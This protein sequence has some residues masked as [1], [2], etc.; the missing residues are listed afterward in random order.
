METAN[1]IGI[2]NIPS[3][4]ERSSVA[5][6]LLVA[7]LFPAGLAGLGALAGVG[8]LASAAPTSGY[9]THQ[10]SLDTFARHESIPLKDHILVGQLSCQPQ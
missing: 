5:A 6:L 3:R 9:H 8:G 7:A 10:L 2:I 1:I 4:P